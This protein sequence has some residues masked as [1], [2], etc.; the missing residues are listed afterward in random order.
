MS[1]TSETKYVVTGTDIYNCVNTAT[2]TIKVSLC[3]G[4]EEY[5]NGLSGLSVYPNPNNGNFIIQSEVAVELQL[6]NQLGQVIEMYKLDD[7]TNYQAHVNNLADGVYFVTGI[8]Q[9]QKF[10]QKILISK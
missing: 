7:N 6:R 5:Q 2:V 9:G 4:F 8:H 10:T 3:P 1:P